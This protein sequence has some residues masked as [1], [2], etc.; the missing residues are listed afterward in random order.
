[1]KNRICV[2]FTGGTIGSY[3]NGNTVEL[4]SEDKSVLIKLYRRQY[5]DTVTFDEFR[6]LDILSENIQF[7]DLDAMAACLRAVNKE[8]YDG[9]IITHGTDTLSFTATLFSQIFCDISLPVV[10]VSALQP[11]NDERSRG[12]ENFAGA[13][14]FILQEKLNGVFV[15]FTNDYENLR[16]HLASRITVAEQISGHFSSVM[17]AYLCEWSNRKFTYPQSPYLPLRESISAKRLP[18]GRYGLCKDIVTIRA[19]SFL[20]F[21]Y[22]N[23]GQKKPKAVIIELYHSGTVCTAGEE[24]NVLKF[25]A[26]CRDLNIAVVLSP[27]DSRARVYSSALGLQDKCILAHD[28]SFEM[29]VV[30]VMLA[31][32]SGKDIK[33]ELACDNFFE[34]IYCD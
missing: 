33:T 31:L 2:I 20:D 1:M 10:F 8:K 9:I 4:S 27:V 6:P 16:I 26:Y 19:R 17:G 32:G 14:D 30:K 29:T 13:V 28:M 22:Y 24:T 34:K 5:G 25:I 21:S 12:V 3:A 7:N 15:S 11:L 18:Y 23:F